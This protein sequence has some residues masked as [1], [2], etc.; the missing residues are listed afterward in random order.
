GAPEDM[1][2]GSVDGL[3]VK[4]TTQCDTFPSFEARPDDLLICTYPNAGTTW[5]QEIV[6]MI[7]HRGDTQQCARAPIYHRIPF[8]DMFSPTHLISGE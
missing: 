4:G 2:D 8:T 6:D 5:M 1:D 3:E 7:Q